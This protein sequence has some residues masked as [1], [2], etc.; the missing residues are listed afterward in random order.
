MHGFDILSL[1]SQVLE[2]NDL[3]ASRSALRRLSTEDCLE[4]RWLSGTD[5]DSKFF[6]TIRSAKFWS[7]VERAQALLSPLSDVIHYCEGDL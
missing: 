1:P 4:D 3:L 2:L 5:K 6:D 7:E